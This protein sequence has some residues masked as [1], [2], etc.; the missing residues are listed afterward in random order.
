MISTNP[1]QDNIGG[2]ADI[3]KNY[4]VDKFFESGVFSSSVIYRNL[5][6]IVKEKNIPETLVK[7]GMRL[8]IGGGAVIDILFPDRDISKWT[9]SDGSVVAR[10]TYGNTSIML[11]GNATAETEKIILAENP[12]NIIKSNVLKVGHNGSKDSTSL[13]FV[14]AVSPKYAL[15]S[16]EKDNKYD[17]PSQET[18]DILSQSDVQ[19]FRTDILGSIIMKSD[20]QNISFYF[21]K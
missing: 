6:N 1:N 12:V 17:Y 11:T 20:G 3:L 15:I 14:K 21:H 2:F 13:L 4:K 9:T 18:L 16:G 5:E 19:V 8:D 7:R 10:L